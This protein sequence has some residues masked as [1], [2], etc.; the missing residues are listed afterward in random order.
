MT[1][2]GGVTCICCM[3]MQKSNSTWSFPRCVVRRGRRRAVCIS[4]RGGGIVAS[5]EEVDAWEAMKASMTEGVYSVLARDTSKAKLFSSPFPYRACCGQ[6]FPA[7]PAKAPAGVM[8]IRR[9][10]LLGAG[11]GAVLATRAGVASHPLSGSAAQRANEAVREHDLPADQQLPQDVALELLSRE[12][13]AQIASRA[14]LSA[15]QLTWNGTNGFYMGR[16]DNDDIHVGAARRMVTPADG[17]VMFDR[18]PT[19][20]DLQFCATHLW[21][22]AH[23]EK[24]RL[25]KT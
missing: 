21:G 20:P 9:R 16:N 8:M 22:S 24:M 18:Q 25:N 23:R 14:W 6:R 17:K 10:T 4:H 19:S 13:L 12:P 5:D 11:A 3:F 1:S 15:Q 7:L 2:P